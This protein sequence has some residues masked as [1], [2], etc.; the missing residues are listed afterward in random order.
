MKNSKINLFS[1]SKLLKSLSNKKIKFFFR[2][3]ADL[4]FVDELRKIVLNSKKTVVVADPLRWNI[5]TT[6]TLENLSVD[7]EADTHDWEKEKN[8]TEIVL[9]VIFVVHAAHFT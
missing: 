5:Q 7:Q 8:V 3:N 4:K 2:K 9:S 1:S 6:L